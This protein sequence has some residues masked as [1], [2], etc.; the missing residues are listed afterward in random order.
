MEQRIT[1]QSTEFLNREEVAAML[2]ITVRT[3]SKLYKDGGLKKY[4][5]GGRLLRFKRSDVIQF[6]ENN[7]F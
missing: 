4:K 6:M 3:L 1:N 5:V 2:K 7:E